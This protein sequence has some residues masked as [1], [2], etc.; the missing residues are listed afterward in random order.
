[1]VVMERTVSPLVKWLIVII[2]AIGFAFDIYE[3]LM[4]PLILRP[5]IL[6]LSGMKP[7]DPG[8]AEFVSH[9]RSLMFY[10][11]A[12]AGGL[13][14]LFGGYL[15]DRLGRRRVL[16]GSILLY[17]IS[18][19]LAGFATSLPMLLVLRCTTFVGVC[20]EFVAAIAWLAELFPEAKQRERVLGYTQAFSSFGGLLVAVANSLANDIAKDLPGIVVPGWATGWWGSVADI[21][22][23]EAWRYTLMSGLIPALPL[24]L[25]RPF[26]PESPIWKEKKDAGT[27][28]RPSILELFTPAFAQ[29]TIVTTIMF[30]CAYGVAFGA[31]QQIPEIVPGLS[32]VGAKTE[33]KPRPERLQIEQKTAADY[34]KM[35]E[36]GGLCGRFFLAIL[37]VRIVSRRGLLHVFQVPALIVVP[38]VFYFF[39]TVENRQFATIDL[40]RLRLGTLPIT[41][42]SLGVF[43]AGLLTVA[44]FSFW[45]NYLP[46][47]YPVHLRGTGESFAANI[48]G[49][50]IGSGFAAVTNLLAAQS[51][52]PGTTGPQKFAVVAAG[53]ALAVTTV[54]VVSS[55]FLPEPTHTSD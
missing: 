17:S 35:Q 49:R 9:W 4:L 42:V 37:A 12:A 38:L 43:I 19:F 15:T 52:I 7:T 33:G 3:L 54:G 6:E 32:D 31:I 23:H 2:A 1:M 8:F 51:F 22:V 13:I 46:R 5:A 55:F 14:G 28:K 24:I 25:I 39:L 36:I 18:A 53:V 45:G 30:A 50:M 10:V 44:Q 20:V 21:H 16:T 27:L 26:L 41:T 11:P 40:S 47:L 29:T 48:G 34:T